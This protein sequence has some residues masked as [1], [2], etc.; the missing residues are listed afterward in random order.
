MNNNN[1]DVL[2][3]SWVWTKLGEFCQLQGGYAF[4]S[5]EFIKDGVP[6]IRISNIVEGCISF[7]NDTV[8]L[9]EK[10]LKD[11]ASFVV[12]KGDVLIAMSGATTGKYGIF[13]LDNTP[14]LNQRVGRF[15]F[16]TNN[17]VDFQLLYH[18]LAVIRETIL[19]EAYGA[20]QPNISSTDIEEFQ[21]PLP[22]LP[23]QKRI[24]AKIEELFSKLD[25]GVVALKNVKR[26]LKRYRQSVLA[27]SFRDPS[28]ENGVLQQF[29]KE[30]LAKHSSKV[31]SGSTP[32]GGKDVYTNSGIPFIRSQNVHFNRFVLDGLVHISTEQDEEMTGTRVVINDVLLNITGA[33]IGRVCVVPNE[34]CPANVNQHVSI[35]RCKS[36]LEPKFLSY[37]IA[38]PEMQRFIESIQVGTTRQALTKQVIEDFLI[39]LPSTAEQQQIVSEIERRFSVADAVEQTIDQALAQSTRLRQSILKRAFAGKLVPQDPTDEPA[40]ILLER[41]KSQRAQSQS[42][43]NPRT[44]KPSAKGKKNA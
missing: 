3:S 33:S 23:E 17:Q 21:F 8:Y 22:P 32:R 5:S 12:H 35:I 36:S 34:V 19:K 25:A 13:K 30:K 18:Y 24:V 6:L 28:I 15:R 31:G 38:S 43:S 2:P 16:F 14:L 29:P 7:N 20:A 42:T 44:R 10:A 11:N 27:K 40:S 39:P 9:S 4:K 41:I 37:Y 26:E 1:N